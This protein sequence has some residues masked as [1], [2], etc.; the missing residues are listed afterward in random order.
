MSHVKEQDS[1]GDHREQERYDEKGPCEGRLPG[2][3]GHKAVLSRGGLIGDP[4]C[5]RE[6]RYHLKQAALDS[7]T[8]FLSRGYYRLD[9][10]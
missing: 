8:C 7:A 1:H 10:P 4:V 2:G 5:I 6:A 9:P 3:V